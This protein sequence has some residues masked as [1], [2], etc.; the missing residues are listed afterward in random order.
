MLNRC[1][2][3]GWILV[4]VS[5]VWADFDYPDF[6]SA[7]GLSI[8]GDA[9]QVGV[10]LELTPNLQ[11]QVGGFYRV[12]QEYIG[13]GFDTTFEFRVSMDG[14]DGIAFLIQAESATALTT[15]AGSTLGYADGPAQ[16][17]FVPGNSGI[18][19]SCAVEFD[20][21]NS[22][23]ICYAE[24]GTARHI[25]IQ[26][27]IG[28]NTGNY[29]FA[30]AG[31]ATPANWENGLIHTVRIVYDATGSLMQVYLDDLV[32]PALEA[33]IDLPAA[34]GADTAWVGFTGATGGVTARHAI[35]SWSYIGASTG[36]TFRRGDVN[37]DSVFDISDAVFLLAALFIPGSDEAVCPDA[38][39]IND[40][41]T[42]DVSDAVYGLATLFIPGSLPPPAPGPATCG[43]DPSADGLDPCDPTSCP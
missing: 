12:D 21:W 17:G 11:Q 4:V 36:P 29:S 33:T 25:A 35:L 8:V 26:P 5:P 20:G 14:A 1:G 30:A 10:E 15:N 37:D 9:S 32:T 22:D 28:P 41:G 42:N 31:L 43:G 39:D 7:S 18:S 34:I 27:S 23:P 13:G 2:I 6:S 38:A 16:C 19:Q 24:P 40:D 3:L